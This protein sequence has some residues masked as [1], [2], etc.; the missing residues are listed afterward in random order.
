VRLIGIC[1]KIGENKTRKPKN[2]NT[3]AYAKWE[4]KK[5]ASRALKLWKQVVK[6]RAGGKCQVCG[7]TKFVQV[8]HIEDFKLCPALRYDLINGIA[9]CPTHHKFGKD[10]FH[11]SFIFAYEFMKDYVTRVVYLRMHRNDKVWITKEWLLEQIEFLEQIKQSECS[12]NKSD[13]E[14]QDSTGDGG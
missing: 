8:H 10:S 7:A 5:L 9:L 3:K 11:R 12:F 13:P 4:L 1:L 2:K 14:F 6:Q